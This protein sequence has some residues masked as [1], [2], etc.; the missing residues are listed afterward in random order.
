MA[1]ALL[2]LFALLTPHERLGCKPDHPTGAS[3]PKRA[4]SSP[5][6]R[7]SI[8]LRGTC[9]LLLGGPNGHLRLDFKRLRCVLLSHDS[10]HHPGCIPAQRA[11]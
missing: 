11:E 7:S 5:R 2:D 6:L 8:G 4:V 3:K 1:H 10:S 9:R